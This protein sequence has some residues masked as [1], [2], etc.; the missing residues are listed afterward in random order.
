MTNNEIIQV[1]KGINALYDSDIKLGVKLSYTLAKN[2]KLLQPLAEVIEEEQ[3]K[4][5][6]KYGT[7]SDNGNITVLHEHV[8]DL[9][10]DLEQ[11]GKLENKVLITKI[12]LDDFNSDIINFKTISDLMPIIIEE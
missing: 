11:L 1:Y 6:N 2:L 8:K 5:F 12:K 7:P 3:Y 9:Q 10:E 4:I